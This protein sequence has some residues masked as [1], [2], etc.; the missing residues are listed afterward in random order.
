MTGKLLSI[1]ADDTGA[2]STMR[3][4]LLV[5]LV[6][7]FGVW[8]VLSLKA[9]ALQP[10]PESLLTLFGGLLT[11]KCVQNHQEGRTPAAPPPQTQP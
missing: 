4:V 2:L 5:W 1:L 10:I 3:T 9:G 7:F 6:G 8:A 11:A